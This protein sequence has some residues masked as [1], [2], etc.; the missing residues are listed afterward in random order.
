M[1]GST[2]FCWPTAGRVRERDSAHADVAS[3]PDNP[4]F[5]HPRFARAHRP[6]T[7]GF[8][9]ST[10]TGGPQLVRPCC[11]THVRQT[12]GFVDEQVPLPAPGADPE[13]TV[14]ARAAA[15]GRRRLLRALR[16]RRRVRAAARCVVHGRGMSRL[17]TRSP[18]SDHVCRR[19]CGSLVAARRQRRTADSVGVELRA[20]LLDEGVEARLVEKC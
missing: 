1:P 19:P 10:P 20:L 18:G 12:P 17:G 14:R 5:L 15:G 13:R 16:S 2:P 6:N 7:T 8:I 3:G 11:S 9:D 4:F